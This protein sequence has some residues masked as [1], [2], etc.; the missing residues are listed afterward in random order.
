MKKILETLLLKGA[1]KVKSPTNNVKDIVKILLKGGPKK[2][3]N[4]GKVGTRKL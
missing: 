3:W 1:K 4:Q 2:L